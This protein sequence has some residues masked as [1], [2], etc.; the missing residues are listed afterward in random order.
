MA[1]EFSKIYRRENAVLIL[2]ETEEVNLG[3]LSCLIVTLQ[4]QNGPLTHS[5]FDAVLRLITAHMDQED[6]KGF[7]TH[8]VRL[9]GLRGWVPV[10]P[11]MSS[12]GK[13][14]CLISVGV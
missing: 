10:G 2:D 4:K 3:F 8:M 1:T 5:A 13:E 14:G 9:S 7:V 6:R 12:E 11:N